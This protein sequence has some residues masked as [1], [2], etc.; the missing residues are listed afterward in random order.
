M[1]YLL[2]LD[3]G[4]SSVKASLVDAVSGVIVAQDFMPKK[5]MPIKEVMVGLN[6]NHRCGTTI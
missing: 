3:I 6:R 1:H 4:S 2:G 5:E